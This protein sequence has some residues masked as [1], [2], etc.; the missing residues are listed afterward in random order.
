MGTPMRHRT[1]YMG[2]VLAAAGSE[3][4][5]YQTCFIMAPETGPKK[6]VKRWLR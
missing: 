6:V 5:E 2:K 3:R 1:T 4:L